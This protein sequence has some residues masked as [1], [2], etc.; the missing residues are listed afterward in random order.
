[1]PDWGA[2]AAKCDSGLAKAGT[3]MT[4]RRTTKGTYDPTTA[5]YGVDTVVDYPVNGMCLSGGAP[6]NTGVG[7]GQ[8]FFNNIP[9]QTDDQVVMIAAYGLEIVPGPGDGVIIGSETW[10]VVSQ[11]P[12]NPGAVD[13]MYKLLLRK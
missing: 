3:I 2:I 5:T 11:V 4:L 8:R 1:M 10:M 13:L 12:V 7:S 6:S 9:I